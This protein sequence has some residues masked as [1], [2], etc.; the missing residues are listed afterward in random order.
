MWY[1]LG[2]MAALSVEGGHTGAVN[3]ADD[4]MLQHNDEREMKAGL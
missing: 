1:L 3:R 4:R 2:I